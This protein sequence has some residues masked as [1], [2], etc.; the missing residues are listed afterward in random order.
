VTFVGSAKL[1]M[2]EN[3]LLAF[4]LGCDMVNVGREAMLAIGC[5]QAQ[6]CH[7]DRCPT[8]VTTHSAWLQRGLDPHLKSVRLA[9]YLV[10]LRAE[11]V[12]LARTCGVP[13]P[14]FTVCEHFELLD[15][16]R[17]VPAAERFGYP[18]GR[19]L[20]SAD[21]LD[22]LCELLEELSESAPHASEERRVPTEPGEPSFLPS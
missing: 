3:A 1:G 18:P 7:T 20:P 2:P 8:G 21:D 5:I 6:R 14:A 22:D 11:I 19:G 13:H 15:G 4:A 12:N 16:E 10:G 9:S 17:C